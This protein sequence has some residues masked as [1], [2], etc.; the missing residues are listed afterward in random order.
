LR[1]HARAGQGSAPTPVPVLPKV[2]KEEFYTL[3]RVPYH[4]LHPSMMVTRFLPY[5]L[6]L[7]INP[8]PFMKL[9]WMHCGFQSSVTILQVTITYGDDRKRHGMMRLILIPSDTLLVSYLKTEVRD[10]VSLTAARMSGHPRGHALT[11]ASLLPALRPPRQPPVQ[12]Q[13]RRDLAASSSCPSPSSSRRPSGHAL[14]QLETIVNLCWIWILVPMLNRD[15]T[16]AS[17]GLTLI[18]MPMSLDSLPPSASTASVRECL[19]APLAETRPRHPQIPRR[20]P[21]LLTMF[22]YD[23]E[24]AV[25]WIFLSAN[26]AVRHPFM[27]HHVGDLDTTSLSRATSCGVKYAVATP[28]TAASGLLQAAKA[29]PKGYTCLGYGACVKGDIHFLGSLF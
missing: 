2:V 22:T 14:M 15:L 21:P 26:S 5:L 12:S 20:S 11:I 18:L 27:R 17:F 28:S 13:C 9:V 16:M 6:P 7:I 23:L 19:L 10:G 3:H 25:E 4:V 24:T 8:P 1:W 29:L